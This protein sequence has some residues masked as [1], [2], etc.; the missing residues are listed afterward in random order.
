MSDIEPDNLLNA[1]QPEVA[2]HAGVPDDE[3][4]NADLLSL[5]KNY[6][7]D[8]SEAGWKTVDEY[9][10]DEVA[11]NL[12]DEKKIRAA[13]TRAVK[14]MNVTKGSNRSEEKRPAETTDFVGKAIQDLL[15]ANLIR[16]ESNAPFVV[17]PLTVS[18]SQSVDGLALAEDA[19][20]C[21]QQAIRVKED[22][23]LS[24]FVPNKDKCIW[25]PV[26]NL[27]WL[28]FIWDLEHC[29]FQ[30]LP[31][32]VANLIDLAGV[33]LDE[34]HRVKIRLLA[35]FCGRIISFTPVIGNVTQIMTRCT[36]SV[37]N[38][39]DE[40][41]QFVDLNFYSGSIRE[42]LFWRQNII[43]LKPV[44]I[45]RENS[46]F[47]LFTDASDGVAAGFVANSDY[48]MHKQWLQHEAI[49]SSAWRELKA[50]E[51]SIDSFKHLLSTS[52]VS[53]FTDNQ[54]AV[55][56][57]QKG[58]KVP[59]LQTLAL[60]IFSICVSFNISLYPRWIPR[61]DNEKKIFSSGFWSENEKVA[62]PE[63]RLLLHNLPTTVID[64][65]AK[66]TVDKFIGGF[67][68]FAKW[69]EK[70]REIT[71]ILPCKEI[72][73]GLYLQNLIESAKHFSIIESAFYSI[74]WAHNL[75]GV[76]IP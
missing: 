23:I 28:G 46:D 10:S 42:I 59:E 24:G 50:V 40:W 69:T 51:L 6:F 61:E 27:V 57:I 53:F 32:K 7:A 21:A 52:L 67:K 68:R 44:A 65:R 4:S 8:K 30:L 16:E 2:S 15:D 66:S 17:N 22:L 41:D 11:S 26:Q 34:P 76:K 13:E 29:L 54:N 60:S 18:I 35:I 47:K 25:R 64:A 63:L 38:S 62:H 45:L 12:E 72:D 58:S 56:I 5:M 31:E 43:S 39:R 9:L 71:C 36:F 48:I 49:K 19:Q 33:I 37:I 70:Y 20:V 55:G 14:K 73:V 3:F 75:A 1:I 74:R